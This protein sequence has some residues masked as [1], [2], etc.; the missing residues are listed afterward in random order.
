M[1]GNDQTGFDGFTQPH[2]VCQD[3]APR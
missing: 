3:H 2:F 1:L